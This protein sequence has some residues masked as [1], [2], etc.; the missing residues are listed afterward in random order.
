MH[1]SMLV[2]FGSKFCD[3]IKESIVRLKYAFY[4]HAALHNDTLDYST[5]CSIVKTVKQLV[6]LRK[7]V[8]KAGALFVVVFWC[9]VL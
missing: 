3:W 2:H 9:F 7:S 4:S 1:C 8:I 6:S 5:A